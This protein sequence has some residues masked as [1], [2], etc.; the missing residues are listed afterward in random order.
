M[1]RITCRP[2]HQAAT[3]TA[4]LSSLLSRL[5]SAFEC[6]SI[7]AIAIAAQLSRH[8]WNRTIFPKSATET[9]QA[10]DMRLRG[11]CQKETISDEP[12]KLPTH[13]PLA[14]SALRWGNWSATPHS[15]TFPNG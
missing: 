1:R 7:V 9:E 5:S 8:K 15:V 14:P 4:P 11:Y 6:P 12:P 2:R 3:L 10:A 13:R